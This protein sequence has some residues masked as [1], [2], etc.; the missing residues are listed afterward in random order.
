[1]IAHYNDTEL[2]NGPNR[3]PQLM[4]AILVKRITVQGFIIFDDY[5]D[6]M[7]RFIVEMSRW[8]ADGSIRYREDIVQGLEHA[9]EAFAGLLAGKN[10]GK[11]LIEM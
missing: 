7:G 10:F 2:P 8:I 6:Q 9:P 5:G 11:L 4:R 3:L 1:M